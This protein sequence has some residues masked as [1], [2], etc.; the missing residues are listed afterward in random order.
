METSLLL[1]IVVDIPGTIQYD[2]P[3]VDDFNDAETPAYQD[4]ANIAR[5]DVSASIRRVCVCVCACVCM[6]VCVCVCVCVRV[7]SL[8]ILL[9]VS[10]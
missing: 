2:T 10:N 1:C 5:D 3:F 6:C 7:L 9:S 4:Q 8:Y